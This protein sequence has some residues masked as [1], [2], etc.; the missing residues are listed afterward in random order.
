LGAAPLRRFFTEAQRLFVAV[1]PGERNYTVGDADREYTLQLDLPTNWVTDLDYGPVRFGSI[2]LADLDDDGLE[3]VLIGTSKGLDEQ[4]NEVVPA[5]LVCLRSD[6]SICWSTE[7]PAIDGP[8]P[9]SGKTYQTT[10]VSS[11]PVVGDVDGDGQL[12]VVV[13]VGGDLGGEAQTFG[14]AG[15][16]EV[17]GQP[18]DKGGVYAVDG[19]TGSI[20]WFHESL[21]A[22][23][24]PTNTGDGRPDGVFGTPRI[25][26]L[27]GTPGAEVVF[28]AWDRHV[29]LLDGNTGNAQWSKLVHDT[30]LSSPTLADVDGDGV[31]EIL[32]GADITENAGAGTMS[33]GVFHVLEADDGA[34]TIPGFDQMINMN[35]T[36]PAFAPIYGK[37]EE[38][39]LWS[40]P[41][42]RD[43][44]GDGE[45][46]IAYGTSFAGDDPSLGRFVRVWNDDGTV[47][48][49]DEPAPTIEPFPT[50]G[51]TF[52]SVL[53]ADLEGDGSLELLAADT[54]GRLV[55]WRND[56]SMA[57]ETLTT[58]WCS[59][60]CD[61]DILSSPLAVDL[62]GDDDLEILYSQGSQVVVV[63]TDGTQLSSADVPFLAMGG[64]RGSPAVGD[65]DDDGVIDIVAAGGIFTSSE[66]KSSV[67]SWRW[68]VASSP[69]GRFARR[70]FAPEPSAPGLLALA[71]GA[72]V[73]VSRRRRGRL[74]DRERAPRVG[75]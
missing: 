55:A 62:D 42:A 69:L 59:G 43:W 13:G 61:P 24:G 18:G 12:D 2:T 39:V 31:R 3:E 35:P 29:W 26:E 17:P 57:F 25:A 21:D 44:D 72:V 9:F 16:D 7:F 8:D 64:F 70:Q 46:E 67:F 41:T 63:D 65:I 14:G 36:N 11:T 74:T 38:Q 60:L 66:R 22:I 58:P 37:F 6:G 52:A 33:G 50:D 23:G 4:L 49:T 75:E 54:T 15:P 19:A 71:L 1:I 45:L 73:L 20:K 30:L 56:G 10:S 34:E 32:I 40:S 51:Q 68:E 5:G 53:F 28:G 47:F 48:P 27:D